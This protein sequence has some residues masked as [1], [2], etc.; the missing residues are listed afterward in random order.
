MYVFVF[1]L[2]GGGGGGGFVFISYSHLLRFAAAGL[3][4]TLLPLLRFV[5][6][7]F[8]L[9]TRAQM[10]HRY[11]AHKPTCS[12]VRTFLLVGVL[13]YSSLRAYNYRYKDSNVLNESM[14]KE[15]IK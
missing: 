2:W 1:Y 6:M 3:P 13:L 7:V 9:L 15:K 8:L 11:A 14:N 12:F 10:L 4:T 5:S